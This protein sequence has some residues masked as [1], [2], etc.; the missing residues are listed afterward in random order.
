[1]IHFIFDAVFTQQVQL[2]TDT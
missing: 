2:L 1:M